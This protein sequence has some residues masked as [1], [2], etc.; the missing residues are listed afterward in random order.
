MWLRT[1]ILSFPVVL[2]ALLACGGGSVPDLHVDVPDP[3]A[4]PDVD[5]P[6]VPEP[7]PP[8]DPVETPCPS[9]VVVYPTWEGEWPGPVVKVE[10]PVQVRGRVGTCDPAPVV[11]CTVPA[12]LYHPWPGGTSTDY[13]TVNRVE[14]WEA[15]VDTVVDSRPVRAGQSVDVRGYA[16]EGFCSLGFEGAELGDMCPEMSE[17]TTWRRLTAEA[18]PGLQLFRAA[19]AEGRRAWIHVDDAFMAIDGV[20]EGTFPEYGRVAP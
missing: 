12:G 6:G 17:G 13:A 9:D 20:G 3:P 15:I 2:A 8:A 1:S 18:G 10:R 19:C 7:A 16:G 4:R 11:D 5:A 14:R